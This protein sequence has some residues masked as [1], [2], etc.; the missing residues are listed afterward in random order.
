MS[1]SS[2]KAR[3]AAL[4]RDIELRWDETRTCWRDAKSDQFDKHYMIELSAEVARA[5]EAINALDRLITEVRHD[6]E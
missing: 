2:T 5:V 6:C 4:T 3:L 1:L